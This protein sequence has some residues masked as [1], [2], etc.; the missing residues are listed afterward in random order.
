MFFK[1]GAQLQRKF[2][3]VNMAKFLR[4]A[5]FEIPPVAASDIAKKNYQWHQKYITY[6]DKY[7]ML[8][9]L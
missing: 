9:S 7:V 6:K 4:T 5:F 2:F 1:I 8:N 3:P